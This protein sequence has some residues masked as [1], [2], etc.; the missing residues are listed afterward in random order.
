MGHA[1]AMSQKLPVNGFKWVKNVSKK[2]E[3]FI[4]SYDEDGD[5]GYFIEVD[6]KYSR[7]LCDLNNNLPFLPERKKINKCN[8]LV[9]NLYDKNNYVVHIRALKQA[10]KDG[11]KLKKSP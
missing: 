7:E 10:L 8:K 2:D 5:I 4:K 3:D 1:W 11:L 9:Y 6:I